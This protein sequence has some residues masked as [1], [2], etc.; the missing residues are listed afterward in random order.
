MQWENIRNYWV[1]FVV[2]GLGVI[3]I[4]P[5]EVS[6]I[7]VLVKTVQ[8]VIYVLAMFW[9][10]KFPVW[11]GKLTRQITTPSQKNISI[12]SNGIDFKQNILDLLVL[13]N[14]WR[15]GKIVLDKQEIF[16]STK[17]LFTRRG[18]SDVSR[19]GDHTIQF[20]RLFKNKPGF[21]VGN[22]EFIENGTYHFLIT[23]HFTFPKHETGHTN[24]YDVTV[25]YHYPSYFNVQIKTR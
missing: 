1:S 18:S 15:E 8:A 7:T 9:A 10:I 23:I 5:A 2:L 21:S 4:F 17:S 3:L 25:N 19:F 22:R 6:N 20:I 14:E 12:G 11:L 24:S 13:N 16:W